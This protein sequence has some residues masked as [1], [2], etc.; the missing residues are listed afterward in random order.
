MAG[1]TNNVSIKENNIPPT[2]TMPKGILLV[3]AAPIDKA[4]GKAPNDMAR[5]V[6]R[7]GRNLN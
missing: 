2:I 7:I 1:I 5:L 4:I 3:D 6:I